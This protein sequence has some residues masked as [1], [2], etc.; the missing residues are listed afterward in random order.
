LPA[1]VLADLAHPYPPKVDFENETVL[2]GRRMAFAPRGEL[3]GF[4]RTDD[5]PH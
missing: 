1:L 5:M 2:S 4:L 3:R